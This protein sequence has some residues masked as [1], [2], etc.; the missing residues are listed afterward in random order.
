MR[1][2]WVVQTNV[3]PESTSPAAL[4]RACE[5]L[6]SPFF[7]LSVVPRSLALPVMPRVDGPVVLHGRTTLILRALEHPAWRNGI[8]FDPETFRHDVYAAHYGDR[9]LNADARV[10][11]WSDLNNEAHPPGEHLFLKPNDDL[12]YFTGGV[13]SFQECVAMYNRLMVAGAPVTPAT[14]VVVA[15]PREIDAEWRLFM[16]NGKAVAGSMYRPSG[17]A[18]LPGELLSFAEKMASRW[19]PAEV[20]V[21]DVA[22]SEGSWRIVECNCFNG[23]RF[24]LADVERIVEE[25]SVY[26]EARW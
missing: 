10:V 6:Q 2:A 21:L 12:K 15:R 7:E 14:E 20:F 24:Y 23:S 17:D 25:V 5:A 11:P 9:M 26:Q 16:V 18:R 13:F 19:V 3:E 1:T 22:R 8:F 4:R